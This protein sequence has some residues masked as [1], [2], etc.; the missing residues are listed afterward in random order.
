[1][2]TL[3][4]P[5]HRGTCAKERG[6]AAGDPR[7]GDR[8]VRPAGRRP[9]LNLRAI[10]QEVGV[11][12]ALTHYFGS[13]GE[14]LVAVYRDGSNAPAR[15]E[16]P[17]APGRSAARRGRSHQP[18][19]D[20]AR[21]RRREPRDPGHGAAVFDARVVGP[22]RH[23]PAAHD[24]VTERFARLRSELGERVRALQA[25]GAL[26]ADVPPDLVAALVIA[27]S[28]GLQTRWLLDGDV[29]HEA[30]LALLDRLLAPPHP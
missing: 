9:R 3:N 13:L 20:D 7:P 24:F 21:L 25:S 11:T 6:A 14:L 27:A 22:R 30:A 10:A 28:D 26:R 19:R 1:M 15:Q 8:G 5:R 4:T 2:S 29:D 23:P 18:R 16:K 12:A 17:R